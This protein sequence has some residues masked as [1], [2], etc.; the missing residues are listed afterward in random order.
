MAAVVI[1]P[2]FQ[3]TQDPS[4]VRSYVFD[5][6]L[7]NL[8]A[9]VAIA[10]SSF[11]V[12]AITPSYDDDLLT[13]ANDA[14]LTAAEASYALDRVVTGDFRATRFQASGGTLHQVYEVVN[15]ITT[16]ETPA[17]TKEKSFRILV[18]QE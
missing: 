17:Q 2:G 9:T 12:S 5:W 13:L 10:T 15:R 7:L 18:E 8:P 6:D 11:R 16:N 4:A 14:R 1:Y 3:V